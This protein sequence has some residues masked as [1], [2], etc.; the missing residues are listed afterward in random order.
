MDGDS[1]IVKGL[2]G[3]DDRAFSRAYTTHAPR[4]YSFL[5]RLSRQRVVAEDLLQETFVRLA[6][7]APTLAHDTNLRAWLF[8]V[9][10][11]AYRSHARWAILDM[12]RLLA[13][14]KETATVAPPPDVRGEAR[15]EL[16]ELDEALGALPQAHREVLLLVAVEGLDHETVAE[17]LSIKPEA[18]RQRLSRARR[19]LADAV[20]KG[21]TRRSG[22]QQPHWQEPT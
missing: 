9:A 15:R 14:G 12:S 2:L 8:T 21:R 18:V 7:A 5:L 11:N 16:E 22:R 19:A 6:K 1:E 13:F 20:R 4:V 17:M 3:G 10:R